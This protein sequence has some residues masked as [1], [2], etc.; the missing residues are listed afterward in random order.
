MAYSALDDLK[1]LLPE[2]RIIELTDDAE[3]GAVDQGVLN[4]AIAQADA[5]IDGYLGERYSVPLA[6]VPS[7]IRKLSVDMAVYHLYS[8]RAEDIPETRKD[9]YRHAVRFLEGVARGTVSLGVAPVPS[10]PTDSS[11]ETNKSTDG[12]VFT[13]EKLK[14]F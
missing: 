2:E 3:S 10:A 9:R 4:E 14:G 1:K 12:N 13:R 5:E 6:T 11:A 7:V 8:R